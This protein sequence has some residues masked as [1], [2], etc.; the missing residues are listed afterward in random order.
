MVID[1]KLSKINVLRF[2][3]TCVFFFGI[4]S[5]MILTMYFCHLADINVGMITMLWN[6]TPYVAALCDF[7]FNRQ[8]L[9]PSQHLGMLFMI[10]SCVL[11]SLS[12]IL[13]PK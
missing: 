10:A 8:A 5:F 13:N 2:I 3:L 6:I 11:I 7:I 4:Q 9:K 1:G 12:K